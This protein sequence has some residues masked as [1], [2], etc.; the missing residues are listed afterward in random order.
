[1]WPFCCSALRRALSGSFAADVDFG[2]DFNHAP[3]MALKTEVAPAG[4]G[5][6]VALGEATRFDPKAALAGIC[7]V[8]TG[9]IVTEATDFIGTTEAKAVT[10]KSG[11]GVLVNRQGPV[12]NP[13]FFSPADIEIGNAGAGLD[14]SI[15]MVTQNNK[16]ARIDL[17]QSTGDLTFGTFGGAGTSNIFSFFDNRPIATRNASPLMDFANRIRSRAA[18]TAATDTSG[19]MWMDDERALASYVGRG[20]NQNNFSGFFISDSGWTALSHDDGAFMI[21]RVPL[22]GTVPTA[23]LLIGSR[24]VGGGSSV[25][26]WETR[27]G[28]RWPPF[29]SRF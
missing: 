3:A 18:G 10:I 19:G 17:V 12:F 22:A 27:R 29:S 2:I 5:G 9:N 7:W 20:D 11:I 23:E 14:T 25:L 26:A 15:G 13:I 6:F 24:P 28:Q 8:T 16:R 1:M 21:N 4:S